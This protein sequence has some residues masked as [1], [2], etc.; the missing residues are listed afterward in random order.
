ME[1]PTLQVHPRTRP[2]NTRRRAPC[3][4]S[5]H[6]LV[7]QAP[8]SLALLAAAPGTLHPQWAGPPPHT[9]CLVLTNIP[10]IM[11]PLRP[12]LRSILA[13]RRPL[14]CGAMRTQLRS[15]DLTTSLS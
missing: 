12:A 8:C 15:R 4:A 11:R 3:T 10:F 13:N 2:P 1:L 5:Q 6:P 14:S 9:P 7:A